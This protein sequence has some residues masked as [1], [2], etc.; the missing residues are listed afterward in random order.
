VAPAAGSQWRYGTTQDIVWQSQGIAQVGVD[1]RTGEAQPWIPIIDPVNASAGTTPWLVPNQPTLQARVRVRQVPSGL[2]AVSELFSIAVPAFATGPSPFDLG[3]V[4]LNYA[5]WD[6]LRIVNAGN[7]PLTISGITSSDPNFWVSR[8]AFVIP[9]GK[10]DTIGVYFQPNVIG[11]DESTITFTADDPASPHTLT[12]QGNGFVPVAV[13]DGGVPLAF[14]LEPGRP[15]PFR[16][17][18][19]F[20]YA[21]P[22]AAHA[23]LDVFDLQGRR[24]ATLVDGMRAP[25][26]Y[27]A[28]FRPAA[29]AGEGRGAPA[30]GVYFVRFS[31]GTFARTYKLL[32][33][34]R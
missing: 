12:A 24:V 30:P 29:I 25:G 20:R 31:A 22:E 2:E 10:A 32:Y 14:A 18:T 34:A 28:V 3:T 16:E 4:P 21:L 33:L 23:R 7:G 15:N 13:G 8:T 6:T 27:S 19:T 17:Q 26:T 11:P 1:Y 5:D 9:A